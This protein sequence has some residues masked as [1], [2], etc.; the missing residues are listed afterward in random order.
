MADT[1]LL[2]RWANWTDTL[3]DKQLNCS[4]PVMLK[5][6]QAGLFFVYV[7]M[8]IEST[9]IEPTTKRAIVFFDGQNLF[10]GAREAFGYTYPNYCPLS[11]SAHVCNERG[12][13]LG[14]I[15]FYTGIP[16]PS[17]D[18]YWYQFWNSKLGSLGHRGIVVY[19]RPLP[20]ATKK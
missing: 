17:H 12:W 2:T 20:I 8:L 16:D 6:F 5:G 14:S 7:A 9:L 19:S 4:P 11:L 3:L 1:S 15:R 13:A 18:A 10:H